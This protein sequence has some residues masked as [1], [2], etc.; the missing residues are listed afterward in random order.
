MKTFEQQEQQQK[1][2]LKIATRF[3]VS[4]NQILETLY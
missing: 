2:S 4:Q 3:L 1:T